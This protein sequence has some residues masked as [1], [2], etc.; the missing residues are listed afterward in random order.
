MTPNLNRSTA[1]ALRVGIIAGVILMIAGLMVD[2]T[3]GGEWLL[4]LG[5]LVLIVSPFLGVIVS[6]TVLLLEKDWMW[7]GVAAVLFVVTAIGI[8]ISLN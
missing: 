7:A 3:G 8:I 6:F 2:V 4:Y 1:L 5:I